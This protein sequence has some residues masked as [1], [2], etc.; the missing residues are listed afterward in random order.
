MSESPKT[1]RSRRSPLKSQ[2]LKP[3][4]S[5]AKIR[6]V[7]SLG[8]HNKQQNEELTKNPSIISRP[9][10]PL[11]IE[12]PVEK[13]SPE[14]KT[15]TV[16]P[17]PT[18]IPQE[19]EQPPQQVNLAAVSSVVRSEASGK[20]EISKNTKSSSVKEHNPINMIRIAA[21]LRKELPELSGR[22]LMEVMYHDLVSS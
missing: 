22:E 1:S 19:S 17:I 7:V 5:N 8:Y 6:K 16:A 13:E 10:T 2:R 9:E 21:S 18:P 4:V 12:L 15:E 14:T 11:K 20:S 3:P